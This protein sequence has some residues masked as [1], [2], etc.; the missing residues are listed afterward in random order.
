MSYDGSVTGSTSYINQIATMAVV[1]P[2]D[3]NYLTILPQMIVY[4]ENRIY[5]ELDFL[6]TSVATTAYSLSSGSRTI[7]VPTSTFVVPE[8]INVIT[9][10]GVSDPNL[11][12]RVPLLPTTRD[13]LDAVCGASSTTGQPQY[14]APFGGGTSNWTFLV[15]PYADA[16]YTVEIV[17]T[18]RPDSLSATNLTTFIS[19]YL[20]DL[21][22]MA[23][24]VYISGY[25]RNFG[26]ANDDPQM[27]ITY[28][29]QYQALLKGAM[30]EE[31]RKK[32]EGAAWSSKSLSPVAT[33][34]RG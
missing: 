30:G 32:M 16:N 4:A 19:L 23:S 3:S 21:M 27:A 24:M 13:Y 12:T 2:T 26:R 9:P 14:F 17:G 28:E 7:T 8:Q 31:Y 34:T 20:P 18:F 33:P 5:R 6:F 29:S 1:S 11:G 10:S 22:I 15:G 25:Q